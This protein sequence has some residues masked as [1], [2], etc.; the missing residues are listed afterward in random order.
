MMKIYYD[1]TNYLCDLD[2]AYSWRNKIYELRRIFK[3][4]P[5]KFG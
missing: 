2:L 5:P 4:H 1:G 3:K